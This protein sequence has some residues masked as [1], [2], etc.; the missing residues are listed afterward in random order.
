MTE[1]IPAIIAFIAKI[2]RRGHGYPTGAGVYFDTTAFGADHTYGKLHPNR[3]RGSSGAISPTPNPEGKRRP[4]DFALWKAAKP[5]ELS[6]DSPWGPGRPGW[7]IECSA[8]ASEVFGPRLD[9][10]TGGQ[11]LAFPHHENEIAQSESHHCTDQWCNYFMHSGHVMLKDTKIS[12]SL[13]NTIGRCTTL[14]GGGGEGEI[15]ALLTTQ[16]SW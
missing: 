15:L 9:L 4:E 14:V 1:H 2:L 12:K 8:M 11:D 13:G 16:R 6:W 7:H 10:H 3:Q 5:G